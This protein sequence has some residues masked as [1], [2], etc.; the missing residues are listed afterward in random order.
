MS[1][2]ES[3][4]V[5]DRVLSLFK[6]PGHAV[7]VFLAENSLQSDMKLSDEELR[8][9]FYN[10]VTAYNEKRFDEAIDTFTLLTAI[11]PEVPNF[12]LGFGAA[13]QSSKKYPEALNAF[14][15]GIFASAKDMTPYLYAARC[16]L[17]V[18]DYAHALEILEVGLDH[19]ETNDPHLEE[20][21]KDAD[22]IK[23]HLT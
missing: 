8:E 20:A 18:R 16:C 7:E 21:R 23:A 5:N 10:A 6:D 3:F 12:W 9:F 2:P 1:T 17:Q 14:K 13:L 19:V 22:L 4:A 11:R 15:M